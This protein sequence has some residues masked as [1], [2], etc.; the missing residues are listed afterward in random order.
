LAVGVLRS[1]RVC[2]RAL[3]G[4]LVRVRVRD[5]FP[6]FAS[7]ARAS[8]RRRGA[9]GRASRSATHLS[10]SRSAPLDIL[11]TQPCHVTLKV[12]PG[13]PSLRDR[14]VVR[15]VESAFRRGCERGDFRLVHYSLQDD[16]GD[17]RRRLR[18][19]GSAGGA[20]SRSI[21]RRRER[22]VRSRR[23][24]RRAAGSSRAAGGCTGSWTRTRFRERPGPSRARESGPGRPKGR[25]SGC[26]LARTPRSAFAAAG[27]NLTPNQPFRP[28]RS[29]P[30]RSSAT[31]PP[32]PSPRRPRG[33][34][35]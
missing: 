11:P 34:P 26:S 31:R 7:R 8:A 14:G 10:C 6:S 19:A 20:T 2:A 32:R 1:V 12:R 15:A 35:R 3:V 25:P 18:R 30:A 29:D 16:R 28:V 23:W 21:A 13:L 24:R 17:A 22:F 27:A 33:A 4:R 5:W 9:L